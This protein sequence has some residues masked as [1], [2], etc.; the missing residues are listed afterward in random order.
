MDK[1]AGERVMA[2]WW[3]LVF[4]LIGTAIVIGVIIYYSEIIDVRGIEADVIANKLIDCIVRNGNIDNFMADSFDFYSSC[5]IIDN[6]N[7]KVLYG[8]VTVYDFDSCSNVDGEIV[9]KNQIGE[10]NFGKDFSDYCNFQKKNGVQR[11]LPQCSE[12]NVYS[13]YGD[14]KVILNIIAASNYKSEEIWKS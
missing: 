5:G 4:A 12:K 13:N 11:K 6:S 9:C 7:E 10:K 3:F 14:K 1:K 2:F 8:K